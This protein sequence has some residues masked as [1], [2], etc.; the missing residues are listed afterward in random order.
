MAAPRNILVY[1]RTV[2][3]DT[4]AKT[5][6][7]LTKQLAE[8]HRVLYLDYQFTLKD[9]LTRLFKGA[10][11]LEVGGYMAQGGGEDGELAYR[12]ARLGHIVYVYQKEALSYASLRFVF[13]DEDL[14]KAFGERL[15][16]YMARLFTYLKPQKNG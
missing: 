12:L 8:K 14:N 5:I 4:Y 15:R 16:K 2:W 3:Y 7:D 13:K 1:A 9:L 11:A 6:I 10:A